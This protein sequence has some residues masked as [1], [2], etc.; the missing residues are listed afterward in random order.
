MSKHTITI[1]HHA[2]TTTRKGHGGT[3]EYRTASIVVDKKHTYGEWTEDSQ[4]SG[5]RSG[6]YFDN[7]LRERATILA[8]CFGG[9]VTIRREHTPPAVGT[10]K[11]A[12]ELLGVRGKRVPLHQFDDRKRAQS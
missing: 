11:R 2:K 10:C 12:P 8:E 5:Y 4:A 7:W 1:I 6:K 3:R 9:K